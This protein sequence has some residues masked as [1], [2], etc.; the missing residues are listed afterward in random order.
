MDSWDSDADRPRLE[1]LHIGPCEIRQG[2]RVRL[3]PRGR[4]DILDLALAGKTATV[5]AIEQDYDGRV[6]LAVV[7]DDDPGKD[8]GALRQPGH[9]FFFQPEEVEPLSEGP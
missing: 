5:D 8:L 7:V 1:C 3:R 6:Y 2:G 9:R 4:A